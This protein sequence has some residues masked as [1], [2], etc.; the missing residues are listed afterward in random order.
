MTNFYVYEHWRPD[1]HTCFYVGKGHNRRAWDMRRARN[2]RH[3]F[4]TDKLKRDGLKVDVRLVQDDLSE[5]QA[6]DLERQRIAM[7]RC[8]RVQLTNV[9]DGGDGSAGLKHTEE[10]R[11]KMSLKQRG[12]VV[13]DE[14]KAKISAYWKGRVMTPE[15]KAAFI[16]GGIREKRARGPMTD[17]HKQKISAAKRGKPLSVAHA[18]AAAEGRRL[19]REKMSP[20]G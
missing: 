9:T 14:A 11:A 5:D 16:A 6:F 12:R 17:A 3:K 18:L 2:R 7:W 15:H 1:T 19:K 20:E 13:S 10:S 8:L 4:I